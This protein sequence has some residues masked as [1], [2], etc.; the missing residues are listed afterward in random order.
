[1]ARPRKPEEEK[2]EGVKLKRSL[3]TL[4]RAVMAAEGEKEISAMLAKIIEEP[5]KKRY[6]EAVK[7]LNAIN[8]TLKRIDEKKKGEP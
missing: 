2:T 8:E 4:V 5:L 1:M 3:V 7:K 6:A